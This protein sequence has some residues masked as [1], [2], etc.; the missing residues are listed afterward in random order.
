MVHANYCAPYSKQPCVVHG[1][2]M[3]CLCCM[4]SF[5]LGASTSF[6]MS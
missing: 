4:T 3:W 2:N 6:S 1:A 5:V